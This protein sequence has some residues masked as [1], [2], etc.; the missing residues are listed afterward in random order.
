MPLTTGT[1]IGDCEILSAIG[2]G[3][4]G[5][6]YRARDT[7][8]DRDVAVKVLPDLFAADPD[9]LMRFEREAKTLATLNHP[10]IAQIYGVAQAGPLRALVMEL[11]DGEDLSQQIARGPV[12]VPEA[13]A[14]GAQIAGA[15]EE[16]HEAG[17]VHRDLKPANIK[18]RDDGTVKVLDFGLAK[19]RDA[20]ASGAV[21]LV[22]SPTLTSPALTRMGVVLGTAAYMAPEQARGKAV[23]KRADVWAFG[24]VLYEMLTGAPVFTGE[25]VTDVITGVMT[26]GPD[27]NRLPAGTPPAVRRLLARCL[28]RDPRRRLRDI[29]EARIALESIDAEP[30]VSEPRSSTRAPAW[31]VALPWAV[32]VVA[33]I[34]AA[35]VVGL[36]RAEPAAELPSLTYRLAIPHLSM[37]R[38]TLPAL[39]PD[40]RRL[41]YVAGR[42]LWVRELDQLE[43]RQLSGVEDAHFP[44]WSPDSRQVAYLHAGALWRVQAEGGRPVMIAAMRA[45]LGARTPAGVWRAD[46]TIVFATSAT[47]SSLI[48]VSDQGGEMRTLHERDPA[49]ESDFHRPSLLPD[50]EG[51]L[52]TVDHIGK[53]AD[54]IGLLAR[55]ERKD[56][57]TLPGE[58]MDSPVYSPTGHIVYHRE[59]N[60]P[61]IWAVPFSLERLETTGEPFLVVAGGSWPS[62]TP[63]G[64]L[65]YA[66]AELT[67]FMQLVW[68]D[69]QGAITPAFPEAFRAIHSPRLSPDG[70]RLAAVVRTD[71]AEAAVTIFDLRRQTRAIVERLASPQAEVSWWGSD[72]VVIARDEATQ[73]TLLVRRADGSPEESLPGGGSLPDGSRDGRALVFAR[74]APGASFDLWHL[75]GRTPALLLGTPH[76][77]TQPALSPDATMLAYASN[78]TGRM[79]VFLRPYPDDGPKVQVSS[80]GGQV[81][82]WSPTGDRLYYR[83]GVVSPDGTTGLTAV[84]VERA[85][86]LALGPPRPVALTGGIET[87]PGGF[88]I[89]PDGARLIVVQGVA[90]GTDPALVVVQ[91]WG[92]RR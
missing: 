16:A 47:G 34:A 24:C 81:P 40:G 72:R 87:Y 76:S 55:G 92:A 19:A 86:G 9:R 68:A 4:M 70:Q 46:G 21:D 52:F 54:T 18:V 88:D 41:A 85:N 1:R 3:G 50:G 39:S 15:L 43:P 26:H 5:E 75:A 11:V 17:I 13:L 30:P 67:G 49:T 56:V 60:A 82:R 53:G 65:I 14:I 27:L 73:P 42:A 35:A 25:T 51:L 69:G 83:S 2:A 71:G 62:V 58:V 6:V 59:T 91:N 77:E 45:N 36:R 22:N 23:D 90:G 37:A 33:V 10:H 32:A 79:E 84:T 80:G 8:L 63:Q 61:G 44:F 66:D 78:E 48:A 57:L 12:P 31:R 7:Q 38:T 29:G 89:A 64:M 28:E 74:L 20:V